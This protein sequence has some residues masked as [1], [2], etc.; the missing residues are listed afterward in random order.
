MIIIQIID[1]NTVVVTNN[2]ELKQVLSEDNSYEYIY[3]GSDI[4]ATSEFTAQMINSISG[5]TIV[6]LQSNDLITL[7]IKSSNA[8]NMRFNG[9]TNAMLSVIKI[10]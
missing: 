4:T 8:V 6:S 3:L 9:S 2:D 10:H 1:N 7:N 5:T